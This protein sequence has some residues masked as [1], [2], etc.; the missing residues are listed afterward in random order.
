MALSTEQLARM[1]QLLDQALGLDAPGRRRWLQGLDPEHRD[2]EAALQQALL[3]EGGSR[4]L[5]TLPKIGSDGPAPSISS[6]KAGDRVGPYQ[7]LRELG[8]GG[9]AE[10]WLA[11]RADGAFKREVALKLPALARP[12]QDLAG[13]FARERDILASLEH[14]NIARLYDAGVSPDGLPYLAME[15]IAGQPLTTWADAHRLGLR[16]RLKLFLQVLDAVQYAHEH[17]VLHRDIKPSNVLVTESGQ[18]RL[19]DFGVAKLLAGE[20]RQTQLTE[21]YGQALTPE[22]ASPE[23]LRGDAVD[24]ASDIYAL[25]VLLY[26][27]LAG[28]RPY[29]L[30][31][32]ASRTALE[33]AVMQARVQRPSTQVQPDQALARATTVDKLARRLRGDLDAIVL[34]ALERLPQDR[35]QSASAFAEDLQ[36]YLAGEPVLARQPHPGYRLGKFVQRHRAAVATAAAA[37]L[38]VAGSIGFDR[39]RPARPPEAAA[40]PPAAAAAPVSGKSIAVLP[41]VDMSEKHDQEYFSDGLTEELIDHLAHSPDLRVIARTSSFYFKNRQATIPEI[42]KRLGVSHVLEGSVRRSGSA[43]RITAQLVKASDGAHLWSQTYDRKLTDVFKIQDEITTMVGKA[44]Q[45]ALAGESAAASRA[46]APNI[47]AYNLLLKGHYFQLRMNQHDEKA[48]IDF[49]RRATTLEPD[50]AKAWALLASAYYD[51]AINYWEPPN[52]AMTRAR[53]A[54]ERAI[55]IDPNEWRVPFTLGLIHSYFD[56]DWVAA[57][58]DLDRLRE[59]GPDTQEAA[60]LLSSNFAMSFNRIDEAIGIYRRVLE[61]DPLSAEGL[62]GLATA[63]WL[64]KRPAESAA[65]WRELLQED[66]AYAGGRAALGLALLDLGQLDQALAEVKKEEDPDWKLCNL[67]IV[68]WAMGRRA[69]S[70]RALEDFRKILGDRDPYSVAQVYAYRGDVESA[71]KWLDRTLAQRD[72]ALTSLKSDPVLGALRGDPRYQALL[73]SVGLAGNGPAL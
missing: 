57:R 34:K 58:K 41:F 3:A 56:W 2:L 66:P 17:Q 26:E 11:Q 7:L 20:E 43:L 70:D 69:E 44:L 55:Q 36:R 32:G 18:V 59:L 47:E 54:L 73:V 50:Y 24:A 63:L 40:A 30:K 49:Y 29:R 53:R 52:D 27:L 72:S 67:S 39:K 19:L 25:G 61:R 22:Y 37:A 10:V 14:A 42:A 38:L 62:S 51:Q 5:A 33:Q 9:M 13:R 64:A 6:L 71:F 1:S 35:Y 31:P 8:S 16:E 4:T 28:S 48:A 46:A 60:L 21:L 65:I 68:Y 15:Y 45:V 12:R 23:M